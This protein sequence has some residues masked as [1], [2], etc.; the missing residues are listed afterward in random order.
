MPP[1]RRAVER[2][3]ASLSD[4]P[5][6]DGRS[7]AVASSSAGSSG[8]KLNSDPALLAVRRDSTRDMVPVPGACP[9]PLPP[10]YNICPSPK[11]SLEA[12]KRTPRGTVDF[13]ACCRPSGCG[14]CGPLLTPLL[15]FSD[16]S[17]PSIEGRSPAAQ[18]PA[19]RR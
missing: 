1:V 9:P 15:T 7:A 2:G 5:R 11:L 18:F 14:S 17:G 12:L 16:G 4:M 19:R 13:R 3:D 10:P 6:I 8:L